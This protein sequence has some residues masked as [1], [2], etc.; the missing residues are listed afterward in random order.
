MAVKFNPLSGQFDLV[1]A[2]PDLSGYFSLDQST[3]QTFTGGDVTGTG[4]ISV[5]AGQIGL[6]PTP[7]DLV[8]V[9]Y[10]GGL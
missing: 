5:T 4:V 7:L 3:P 8:S 1:N 10:F 2:A 6:A 9:S